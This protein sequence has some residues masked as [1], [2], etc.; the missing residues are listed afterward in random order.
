M[1]HRVISRLCSNLIAFGE[2]RTSIGRQDWLDQSRMT[3]SGPAG[4]ALALCS[5]NRRVASVTTAR[6]SSPNP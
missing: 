5:A 3:R 2:K 4:P 6:C 1:A